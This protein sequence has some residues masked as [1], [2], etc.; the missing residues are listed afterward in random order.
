MT[1]QE[2]LAC[3]RLAMVGVSRQPRD[4]TRSLFRDLLQ[5]G[6]DV[7]AVNPQAQEIEGRRCFAQVQE[8]TPPVDAVL[9]MTA[10]RVTETVVRDCAAAGSGTCGCIRGEGSGRSAPK[11]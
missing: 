1:P 2:F 10:P 6:Y 5:R 7:V 11:R 8:V 4:F 9:L 3:R